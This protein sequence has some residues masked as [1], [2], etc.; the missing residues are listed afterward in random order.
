VSSEDR[1]DLLG[2]KS[3][4]ITTHY[5]APEIARLV[6]AANRV[7]EQLR[8]DGRQSRFSGAA[9]TVPATREWAERRRC[10]MSAT[11]GPFPARPRFR[12]TEHRTITDGKFDAPTYR[13]ERVARVRH[14]PDE[15]R[16]RNPT[17][18]YQSFP[19]RPF[20]HQTLQGTTRWVV[21]V[22]GQVP[23]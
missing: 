15:L 23:L 2:H 10:R 16:L 1:Q 9:R 13:V 22:E 5:S 11:I 21:D 7:C 20:L 8:V 12:I 17:G 3:D 18:S 14:P 6:E 19:R 4:R